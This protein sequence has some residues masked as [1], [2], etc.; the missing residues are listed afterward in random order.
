MIGHSL[1]ITNQIEV[2]GYRRILA[3]VV[4]VPEQVPST[5]SRIMDSLG[6][7]HCLTCNSSVLLK[8]T[9]MASIVR[10]RSE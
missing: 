3:H 9:D 10:N 6:S 8:I 1:F 5:S 4:R 2:R 7:A